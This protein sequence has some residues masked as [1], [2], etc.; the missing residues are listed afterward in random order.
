MTFCNEDEAR[1]VL[2][3]GT[4]TPQDLNEIVSS[5]PSLLPTVASYPT[6]YPALLDWLASLGDPA[7]NQALATRRTENLQDPSIDAATL[8]QLALTRPDLFPRILEHPNCYPELAGWI[9]HQQSTPAEQS[10][11]MKQ[12][13]P[14]ER[15][16]PTEQV[17]ITAQPGNAPLVDTKQTSTSAKTKFTAGDVAAGI[18]GI[19]AAFGAE[20][21]RRLLTWVILG[22]AIFLG[23]IIGHAIDDGSP[24]GATVVGIIV[25][26]II[27]VIINYKRG[28]FAWFA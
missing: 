10:N 20:F 17:P 15:H 27:G 1:A 23:G 26:F 8:Q 12:S 3:R 6:V 21:F 9:R 25:G 16:R 4:A 24:G 28:Y 5:Y 22:G 19:A 18:G 7:I 14:A 11:P 2:T 13:T